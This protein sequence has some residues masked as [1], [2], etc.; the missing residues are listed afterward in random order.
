[1]DDRTGDRFLLVGGGIASLAAA[2]FLVRDAG[3]PGDRIRILDAGDRPGGALVSGSMTEHPTLYVGTAV[4][5]MEA[6]A[7]TCMWTC[8]TPY[9]RSPIRT[10]Q[11]S[12]PDRTVLD[13]ILET[14][15]E[16]PIEAKARLIG[17]DHRIAH[18]DP[19]LEEG[20]RAALLA[21]DF[22]IL[23]TTTFRLKAGASALDLK[24]SLLQH[25]LDLP[26]LHTLAELRRTR[27]S[28]HESI[29][30][31]L[32][33]WLGGQGVTFTFGATVTDMEFADDG[34]GPGGPRPCP[35]PPSD[36]PTPWNSVRTTTCWRRSGQ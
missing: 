28:E 1:M 5:G 4:R 23:W 19:H 13:E 26:R 6:R 32:H 27:R 25:L 15:R 24:H 36:G 9:P 14:Q 33:R 29:I 18:A 20:D 2:V 22:W 35:S 10:E 34:A 31:P 11:C 21:S 30:R 12:T 7:Y 8:S 3:V 17:A 16:S